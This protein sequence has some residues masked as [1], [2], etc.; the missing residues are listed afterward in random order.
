MWQPT[1]SDR[2]Y[3]ALLWFPS[4]NETS[5]SRSYIEGPHAESTQVELSFRNEKQLIFWKRVDRIYAQNFALMMY[6]ICQ[7]YSIVTD[8]YWK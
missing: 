3:N 5:G 8:L 1:K 2:I 7:S 6:P 4:K